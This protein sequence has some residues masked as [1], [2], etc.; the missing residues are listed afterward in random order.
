VVAVVRLPG[1]TPRVARTTA[2]G[3]WAAAGNRFTKR[4]I[5]PPL[6][7]GA[8]TQKITSVPLTG[9]QQSGAIQ[10]YTGA[11]GSAT[12]PAALTP[13]VSVLVPVSGQYTVRWSV[14]LSG[15]LSGTDANNFGLYQNN[16]LI[17]QSVNPASAG[18][19]AQTPL[20]V[21]LNA[22]DFLGLGPSP[23]AA[24]TGAVYTV[25]ITS[26]AIPLTLQVGPQGLGTTWYPAQMTLSTT[27]GA[28]DT[29][30][31]LVYL[32]S[33]GVPT[34]LVATVFT[35]NGTAALAVPAM[36]P[37]DY[38]IVTWSNGHP[39]DTASFNVIGTQDALTTGPGR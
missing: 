6:P 31:A 5:V 21:Y 33:S 35:G 25:T 27:T 30:T 23:N 2:A 24:T 36:M 39:G 26:E 34:T 38:L 1:W 37:G 28:L 11:T 29:S 3:T 19:Y 17:A 15:T 9:G 12:S 16:T 22:G 7:I 20:P 8:Y 4:T 18:T 32:G 14:G 10:G 13:I